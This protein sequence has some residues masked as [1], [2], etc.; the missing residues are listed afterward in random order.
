MSSPS[1]LS[2]VARSL[3]QHRTRFEALTRPA[4]DVILAEVQQ[5]H[6]VI[7]LASG[8]GDPA[9]TLA[10]AL[11]AARVLATDRFAE[12][13]RETERAARA[14][15]LSNLQILQTDMHQV[16]LTAASV[17]LVTSRL[18]LQFAA[19]VRQVLSEILRVLKAGG[20]TCHVAWGAT[21]QPLL[22]ALLPKDAPFQL[23]EPGP[24]QFSRPGSL[25][26]V[27]ADAGF[28]AVEESTHCADW[29]WQGDARSFVNF[30]QETSGPAR[31]DALDS[32]AAFERHGALIFPVETHVVRARRP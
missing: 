19:D 12:L 29:T 10:A 17:D 31:D 21:D 32:L 2:A 5:V 26:K 24:F 14:R 9:L 30:M 16:P 15:G 4:T 3:A 1:A 13:L 6:E 7:D 27:F 8:T 11:P 23:G 18:G 20:T 25:A 28:A 22:R